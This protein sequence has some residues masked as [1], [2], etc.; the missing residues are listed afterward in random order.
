MKREK[1]KVNNKPPKIDTGGDDFDMDL[2]NGFGSRVQLREVEPVEKPKKKKKKK[3]VVADDPPWFPDP[4]PAAKTDF[5]VA[6]VKTEKKKSA[7]VAVADGEKPLSVVGADGDQ[8]HSLIEDGEWA[9]AQ[10]L[11]YKRMAQSVAAM[12]PY[13]ENEIRSTS[14]KKGA[15]NFNAMLTSA[16][17]LL[18]DIQQAE[19]RGRLGEIMVDKILMP[20]YISMGQLTMTENQLLMSQIR[21]VLEPEQIRDIQTKISESEVRLVHAF[22]GEFD[23]MREQLSAFLER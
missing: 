16:R 9:Q 12:L 18:A 19:D 6:T 21:K 1:L 20:S 17:D 3:E 14:G 4:V 2:I 23:K 10:Q 15:F 5:P 7:V 11:M 8:I 22:Q 13:L